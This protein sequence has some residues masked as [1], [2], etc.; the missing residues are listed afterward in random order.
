MV[1]H[2]YRASKPL[3]GPP[4]IKVGTGEQSK[5][6]GSSTASDLAKPQPGQDATLPE[7]GSAPLPRREPSK[8]VSVQAVK[9]MFENKASQSEAAKPSFLS[10]TEP[11]ITKGVKVRERIQKL[12]PSTLTRQRSDDSITSGRAYSPTS[13][14]TAQG[15]DP[16]P[17]LPQPNPPPNPLKQNQL[18][19]RTPPFGQPVGK[20]WKRGTN[21][22]RV[23]KLDVDRSRRASRTTDDIVDPPTVAQDPARPGQRRNSE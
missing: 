15:V 20:G 4:H 19:Q 10:Q 22:P 18:A 6:P 13:V 9:N 7:S 17:P 12:Q 2:A 5:N 11:G 23:G 21:A 1:E 14:R 16:S 3:G 8:G